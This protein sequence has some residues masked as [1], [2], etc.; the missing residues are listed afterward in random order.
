[1]EEIEVASQ[2]KN[3]FK[4]FNLFGY[5]NLLRIRVSASATIFVTLIGVVTM[6]GSTNN[7]KTWCRR[8]Y[9]WN[10]KRVTKTSS[11]RDNKSTRGSA[12]IRSL[13]LWKSGKVVVA[14]NKRQYLLAWA[15]LNLSKIIANSIPS[16]LCSCMLVCFHGALWSRRETWARRSGAESTRRSS[17]HRLMKI[18][19]DN[20]F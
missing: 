13:Y 16:I 5:D 1:M 18:V 15:L 14:I 17:L 12:R 11:S 4:S 7:G 3:N 19:S 2:W 8:S 6:L 10:Q 9:R 20:L